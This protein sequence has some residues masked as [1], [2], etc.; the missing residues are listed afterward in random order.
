[1]L[2][3]LNDGGF[4]APIIVFVNQKKTA[5]MVCRD[6]QR[7]GVCSFIHPVSLVLHV[8]FDILPSVVQQP[9]IQARTKSNVKLRYRLFG[10]G[11]RTFLS[12]RIWL[13][14]VLMS[15]MCLWSSTSKWRT[16]SRLMYI[17]SVR[18][19]HSSSQVNHG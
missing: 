8:Y 19:S 4:P 16:R 14:V 13:D 18:I 7:G 15:K 1:M 6:L 11:T 5:D 9:S 17:V 2:E 10:M 3:I 12:R